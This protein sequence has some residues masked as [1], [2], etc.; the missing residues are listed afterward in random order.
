MNK[1]IAAKANDDF[2]LDLKFSD[3]SVRRFD[4]KPYL[5]YDVFDKLKDLAYFKR[6]RLAFGTVQWP[7]EEDIAPETLFLESVTLT[8]DSSQHP[9]FQ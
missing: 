3:G 7:H 9:P 4:M 1:V 6:V 2:T 5:K 8:D